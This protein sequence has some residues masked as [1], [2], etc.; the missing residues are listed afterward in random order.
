MLTAEDGRASPDSGVLQRIAGKVGRTPCGGTTEQ[1]RKC[2]DREIGQQR[3]C[4]PGH[5]S[6][7]RGCGGMPGGVNR[8]A[9]PRRFHALMERMAEDR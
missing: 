3:S 1:G 8:Y 5:G 2:P 9:T 7:V 4:M 6:D